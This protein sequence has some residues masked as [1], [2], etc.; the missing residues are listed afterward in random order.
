MFINATHRWIENDYFGHFCQVDRKAIGTWKKIAA[1]AVVAISYATIVIPIILGLG[2]VFCK[3][4]LSVCNF[5]SQLENNTSPST[6]SLTSPSTTSSDQSTS[7]TGTQAAVKV[8]RPK[9]D[10]AAGTVPTQANIF[11]DASVK[12]YED[13]YRYYIEGDNEQAKEKYDESVELLKKAAGL[14]QSEAFF[15][16]GKIYHFGLRNQEKNI[17]LA[18]SYYKSGA[19]LGNPNCCFALARIYTDATIY[20]PK[21][22]DI[23]LLKS[24]LPTDVSNLSHSEKI[25]KNKI[26]QLE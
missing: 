19:K 5:S 4:G 15:N 11:F 23:K 13:G 8:S 18:L 2:Y 26:D 21:A 25:L 1:D 7:P 22:E 9:T 14:G 16:L 3:I 24:Q 6:A 17:D 12:Y 10:P 20:T